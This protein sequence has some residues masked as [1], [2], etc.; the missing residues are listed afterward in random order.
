MC[1][2]RVMCDFSEDC[3]VNIKYSRRTADKFS[4]DFV[5]GKGCY[6]IGIHNIKIT[7]IL[8]YCFRYDIEQAV[9]SCRDMW[10]V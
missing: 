3:I 8:S 1:I 7:S 10:H 6:D 2:C 5:R 4:L 9:Q